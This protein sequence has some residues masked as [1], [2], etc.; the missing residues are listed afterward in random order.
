[1]NDCR[2]Q[3]LPGFTLHH[4]ILLGFREQLLEEFGDAVAF[5]LAGHRILADQPGDLHHAAFAL[6]WRVAV[7]AIIKAR[8]SDEVTVAGIHLVGTRTGLIRAFEET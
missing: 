3:D 2:K 7:P 6:K 4:L 1:M 5:G 8:K